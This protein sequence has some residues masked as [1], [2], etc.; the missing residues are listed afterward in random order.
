MAQRLAGYYQYIEALDHEVVYD[1]ERPG[2]VVAFEHP[3]GGESKG[4]IKDTAITMGGRLVASEQAVIGYVPPKFETEE[5]LDERVVLTGSGDYT[6]P[7]GVYTLT[8]VCIQAGTGAQA[9]FDGEPGGGTQLI[10]TTKEQDAGGSWS[11][12]QADGGEGG[13]KGAPGAGGKVYRATI[14]VVPGQVIHYECGT[15]GVGGATNGAV[16]AAGG[17]TTFGDLSSAQGA[18]SEIGYVDPVTEEELA[19]PG[20]EGV[21]GAAGG[22]GGQASSRGGDYGEN[23]EMCPRTLAARVGL[24]MDGSLTI[25]HLKMYASM[26]V[27][28]AVEPPMGKT[29]NPAATVRRRLAEQGRPLMYPKRRTKLELEEMAGT[30]VAV[31]VGP[32]DCLH[33][34]RLMAVRITGRYLDHE[35]RR[36][37]GERVSWFKWRAGRCNPVFWSEKKT[38]FRPDP[39]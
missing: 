37:G 13:Q 12:T 3:Y 15:P 2:D 11:D 1:G 27:E 7:E 38:G 39:G 32:E 8:V 33:L 6:V 5:V 36:I 30:A 24:R 18:S 21:D 14:D 19:K 29:E 9:G 10:V 28:Q 34:R 23:G 16:G 17:E 20:T 4:C 26:V 35:G 22:R 31:A 25:I